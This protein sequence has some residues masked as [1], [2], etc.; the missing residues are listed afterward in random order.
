MADSLGAG[1]V[2]V[3]VDG[4]AEGLRVL[5]Y[6]CTEAIRDEADLVLVAA[7]RESRAAT[8][9]EPQPSAERADEFLRIA[10]AHVRRQI[11]E[12]VE[13]RAVCAAG[14][15]MKVLS[16]TAR[17]ARTLVIGRPRHRGPERLIA[18]RSNLLLA[19]RTDCPLIVVPGSWKVAPSQRDVAVGV[20]GTALSAEAVAYAFRAAAARGGN[21][22]AVHA[23]PRLSAPDGLWVRKAELELAEVLGRWSAEYPGVKV[24]R[25]LTC[26]PVVAALLHKSREV[27]LVVLGAHAG[28][29]PIGDPITR[30]TMAVVDGPVAI[31]PHRPADRSQHT[32]PRSVGAFLSREAA[33]AVPA[34]KAALPTTPLLEPSTNG[35]PV[36]AGQ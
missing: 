2:V 7:H 17:G 13:V 16:A 8:S 6:A 31:V 36:T 33:A 28:L 27:S 19:R 22:V 1:P 29:L 24:T 11:G 9:R 26:R 3:E 25:Y 15:R 35:T 23:A 30:R 4:S 18:A 20:D 10:T 5:D 14:T 21:L 34:A 12:A 32:E